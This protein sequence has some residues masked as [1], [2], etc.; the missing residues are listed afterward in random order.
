MAPSMAEYYHFWER[1]IFNAITT[2]LL[3][4]MSTYQT[5][6]SAVERKWPPLLRVKADCNGPDIDNNGLESVFRLITKLLINTIRSASSFVR[7]MDGTCVPLVAQQNAEEDQQNLFTF[8]RDVKD[9]P[10]LIEMTLNIHHNIQKIFSIIDRFLRHWKRYDKLWDPKWK[11]ELEKVAERRP[12]FVFFDFH[13]CVYKGLADSLAAYPPEKDIGFVRID[14]T[15]IVQA[16]RAQA[17][18]W[19]AAYGDILRRLAHKDLTKIQ[20]EINEYYEQLQ[21][22]PSS[23]DKLKFI[24]SVIG[25]ILSVSMDMEIRMQDV[26][27]RYRT[28]TLYKCACDEQELNDAEALPDQWQSLKDEARTKDRRM[29]KVKEQFA[30]VTQE[31]VM[32]FLE[33]TK[34]LYKQFRLDGPG[35]EEIELDDGA[36]LMRKYDV[37]VKKFQKRREELVKAQQLFGLPVQNYPEQA[38]LERDLRYLRQ[39]YE[40]Y[41]EHSAMV[42]EFSNALWSKFDINSL[43]KSADEFERRVR[44]MPKETPE[45]AELQ[46]FHKVEEVITS[47][48][49]AVP[50]IQQ[51]KSDA[52]RP[53]HWTELMTIAGQ[54]SADFD[55]KKMTLNAVFT[56]QLH[57]FPDDVNNIVVTAQQELKIKSELDKVETV[58]RNMSFLPNGLKPYKAD[59]GYT[60]MPMEEMRQT[61]EDHILSLQSMASSKYALKLLD[62]IKKWERNLST[63]GEVFDAWLQLQR[64][65]MYLEAIFLDSHD[66]RLQLPEEAKKFDRAHKQFV[67]L[68]CDTNAA[69]QVLPACCKDGRL[70]EFKAL[71]QEFDR[72]QKS[73]TDYLDTKRSAFPRFYLISDEELLSILGTSDPRAVQPHMLK[74]FDN[75]KELE[76]SRGRNVVGMYSD[77][78]EHFRFHQATPAE[79]AVEDWMRAVDEAMQDTLQRI[80]KTAVYYYASEE[81]VLWLQ[82]YVGM[83]AILATQIWWTWGV[84]DAFRKVSE[85]S[86]N[87]MKDELKKENGQVQDLVDLVRTPLHKL[88]QKKVN[89]LI[90]LDVHARDIVDSFVRDSILNK[91][92]FAW[93]SQLR[94]Y[95]D[96]KSDDVIIRQCTGKLSYCYEYQGLNGR[97]V[98]TPLTDRCV[99]TL[100]TALTFNMGGA[101]A[102]PAGTGKT[103]TT[104]DLAKALAISCI[105]TNC[106][107]GLDYRAMGVIFSGLSETGFWGCFDEFNRINVEVLSVVAAQIKTIQNGL[108]AGKK[109]VEMLGRD[110]ALKKTIGYFIT[111]NP[112]YAGR[113]ELPDNLKA[114]FRPVQMIVP[115]LLMICENMLMSEGFNMA[116]VLAKKMTVL[117]SLAQGQLSK[118]YHYDFKL[119]ALKSVLV[120]AG[121]LKRGSPDLTEDL[122]LMRALRDMNMPKFVK[123]DVPLFQD[124]LNDLFPGLNCPRVGNEALKKGI[125]DFFE[126]SKMKPK[127]EEIY[128]LQVD[129]VMQ[130][131][132]TMLTRHSTMVVGPT[133]GG[134]SVVLRAL[135]AGQHKALNLPTRLF[136]LNPKSITTDELYGILNPDTRDWTDGLL[137]KIFR[138]INGPLTD[139]RQERRYI[140]YDGDVDAI[141]IENMNSVMDDNKLLTLTNGERIRLERHCAMLFEVFDLQYAS[142]ATVSRCG[143]LFVDDKNL[144]PSPFYDHWVRTKAT[145]KLKESLE[146]LWDKYMPSLISYIFDGRHGDT[147]GRPLSKFI[148][149]SNMGT[150]SVVQFASLFDSLFDEG[151]TLVEHCENIYIFSL[152]W[153]L[154]AVLDEKGRPEFDEFLKKTANRGLPKPPIFDCYFDME[155]SAWLPWDKLMEEFKP[156]PGIDF[157]KIFVPTM[158]TTRY[159]WVTKKFISMNFPVLFVGESGTAKSV[160][161][162]NTLES[163]PVETSAILNINFSSRTSSRDFQRTLTD[164][165]SKRTGRIFGPEQGKKLRVFIDDLSM[166]KIDTYGTQQ[167]L[168]LLKFLMERAFLYE[169]GGDLLQIII[170]DCQYVS[171]MQ[172]PTAGRNPIDPR[173]VSLYAIIGVTT[174]SPETVER[175][176]TSILKNSFYAFEAPI[177]EVAQKLPQATMTLHNSIIDKMPPTP[178]KFHYIFSLRDLSRVHQGICQITPQV[179]QGNPN[180]LVRLW[181]NECSRIYEDRLNDLKDKGFVDEGQMQSIIKKDFPKAAETALV[182]P[183]VWGDFR[184]IVNILVKSETP[185]ADPRVYE[186]LGSWSDVRPILDAVLSNYNADRTPMQLVLFDDALGHL[187]R[188]HRILR[189]TRGM[190]MLIGI[191][192]SGKQSLVRLGTFTA[193]Y[194]LFEVTLSRGYGDEQLREDLKVLYTATIKQ[195]MTFLFTDA[196]VVEEGFLEYI[197]NILT[198][199]MVPALFAD[200]EKEPLLGV[201]RARAR[202]EGTPETSMWAYACGVIRDNLHLVLAMSPAGSVL[203]TRC[204]NFPGMVA[205]C[206]I[207]WF[208]SWPQEALLAVSHYFLAQVKLPDDNRSGINEII[209]AVHLSVTTKYS[210][211][212]EVKF[213][214]RNFATPKNFLDFL[215]NY[216]KFLEGN[217][218]NLETMS[219]R[220]GG[221]LDKLVQAGEKVAELSAEL[222]IKKVK[223]DANTEKVRDLMDTIIDATVKVTK[224]QEEAAAAA[225][226]ISKDAV[227]ID[228]EAAS[229]DE[230]LKAAMPALAMAEEALEQLEKKDITE[231]KSMATPPPPVM[232]VC[233]CVAILKPLGKEDDS[234]SW[235]AAKAMLADVNLRKCLQEYKKDEMQAKQVNKIRGLMAK[236]KETFE[237]DKMKSISKA[238]FGLLQW[239][240]AMVTYYD[241]AKG[242]E[243][244]RIRVAELQLQ[245]EQAEENLASITKELEELGNQLQKLTADEKEQ[246]ETL[247][248]L[249]DEA[250]SMTRKLNAASQLISGLASER[251]RWTADL[252][253]MSEVRKRLVGDCL[254]CAGFVSYAGPFNHQ[255]RTEMTYNDWQMKVKERS[256]EKSDDF[257][258]QTLLTSD[259]EIAAW[260]GHGLPSDELCVQ[261][262]ILVTRSSRWPLC[263]DPQMQI[264]S[265]IK[266]KEEKNLMVKTFNED[267]IKFLELAV[268]YGKPFLFENL[269]EEIDPMIDP[270]LEKRYVFK[271]GQKMIELGENE[272]EWNEAF[273][274]MMTTKLS[275]PKYTPEV[276]G[277]ASI[278]NCVITLEGLAAQLLNVVVSFERPDLE[279]LRQK[280]VMQMSE[281]RQIIKSLEDTL[282][283][284]LAAAKGSILENDELIA[285][286]N[287]AKTKSIEINASLET[288]AK[289]SEEIDKT[290]S[291]YQKVAKRG[292]ILYFAMAGLVAISEMYEYSLSGYLGVFETALKEAKPDKIVENRLKNLRD[293]MTQ[294]MYDYTCMGLFER[295]KLLFSFQMTTMILDGDGELIHPEFEFYM[296][297]NPSLEKVK[298]PIPHAF[299][300]EPGWKDLQLLKTLHD[301]L[302]TLCDDI[303]NKG[304]LWHTWYDGEAPESV[305]LPCNFSEKVDLFKQVL[306][307]RCLRPDRMITATKGFIAKKLT[308]YFVQPPSL[309]YDKIFEKSNEKMPIVFILSP[310]ADPQSDV[311]KL[312]DVLGFSGSKFKFVS[313]GQGMGDNAALSIEQGFLKGH[314][315]MLQNCHLLASW[316]KTLEK[317]LELMNKPHK[318]FR[319]WLTTMPTTAFPMGILQRSLKVVTEPPEGLKLNIKQSYAKISDAD[320]DG[321]SSGAFRSLIYV[322]AFFHAIVQDRRKFGRIGWNVAYDFNESDYKI[323]ARLLNLYLQKCF[324]KNEVT[325]WET[326]RYL[327]GEAMYGGRVTDQYDRRVLNT[328]L[329]EYLGD[330]IFDQNVKFFFSRAGHDYGLPPEGNAAHYQAH[331]L[332]L[333]INQSPSVFGLHPNAEINYF[334]S[335]AQ[336]IY[337]GLLAMQTG[338]SGDGGGM[339]RDDFIDKT[340][341]EIIK[342]IPMDE[343]KLYKDGVPN[344]LEVVLMQETERFEILSKKM[345]GNLSDLR[346]AIK[347]DIGMSQQLDD[348]GTSMYNGQLPLVWSKAAP[349]TQKPLGSWMEHFLRRYKQY[350]DW[351]D[352]GQPSVF[353]LSGLHI[354]ESLN[355]ALVQASCRRRGWA[356][357]KSTLY[358]KVTKFKDES[359]LTTPLLDGSY[360][361]GFY[362]EGARWDFDNGCLARQLPKVLIQVMPIIEVIPAEANRLKL[363]DELPTPVYITQLRRNAMGVGLVF[364]ANLHTKEHPSLWILQGVAMML[365]DNS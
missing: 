143:M 354:P 180:L 28:L 124:L 41:L 239:V 153:S 157:N 341:V 19:V 135:A 173:V 183:L 338:D 50:L 317:I 188:V 272:I 320:L 213:K 39:V 223:V 49:L 220:L 269:D 230:A 104:K 222:E 168:A 310:G 318:D 154:G 116:K 203:K 95:W 151:N 256:I 169:R 24:L 114:L 165:V 12:P 69:P 250:D 345:M 54:D 22:P 38:Q 119:R 197:N 15:A 207:D 176:Y 91:E 280:L 20:A 202:G 9:N 33:E 46:T 206:T 98:I 145:D 16:I 171:G 147:I 100:T 291:L 281:N 70:E 34:E 294:T 236:D 240:K 137:S 141:W 229:A 40:I 228:S 167:P 117:Y 18:D 303:K 298:D 208:F 108:D 257:K 139:G 52:I 86:K 2:M 217:R 305:P 201:I 72:I 73:L 51:L 194:K 340:A 261:N 5:L 328:Y 290:R 162:Q 247:K 219:T 322:L 97:L 83:A 3:R 133:G 55:I 112:G 184:D 79:G 313:L 351:C 244:K 36:E 292:S 299:I 273:V 126:E 267:Y 56:M 212:F 178:T 332:T 121:D 149:R 93:E 274:L 221:G 232:V 77:E 45:L 355:S 74:L 323:S 233:A 285:T 76:F 225:D 120:M 75:C 216:T 134:K 129:K 170:K 87:A 71:T 26:R 306:I 152:V 142:P 94:F 156:A 231:I 339:S 37:D 59:R 312:G 30:H 92:E 62:T 199:G 187:I 255:F 297:G 296:K 242:V 327:I 346:R 205:G 264:V 333:P 132:E 11:Q 300:S 21:E 67:K 111:M 337:E 175:I 304:D 90:I 191:G 329:L 295:H 215:F 148:Q 360:M 282:L 348:I 336:D 182:S 14:S 1:R 301:G 289:T 258:L 113:S 248:G 47:F 82:K 189:L 251:T 325:P 63:V 174:P 315:V 358:T 7:W 155:M 64:K 103:E 65:W 144:G 101:P 99:M 226:Q 89:T 118:Q 164:N 314:W 241:V 259:V 316:L 8:H 80:S 253:N 263:V 29:E 307:I 146:D 131:Y 17:M 27:E 365:N 78:G 311:M 193:G 331:V 123:Q 265:W 347:G 158:D 359:E 195:P 293:K 61:L 343:L 279:E 138:E 68:M 190:A 6:F 362:L 349:Q 181:R 235:S 326:L 85:G 321:C 218:K 204:R 44:K 227:I 283:R 35:S 127:N 122:V 96:R 266:S 109:F 209:A 278:V 125:E 105:V 234:G 160:T 246:S 243:P 57:R 179:V 245:K 58:W 163:F 334:M 350:R 262:G 4:G 48:K 140:L 357:D 166:P 268:M 10:A 344:P 238:G 330:F 102:G 177:Q 224:R 214:R 196:H 363:R 150:D 198:V 136:P 270:V 81:R 53:V 88:Q 309:V 185:Y 237:G 211:Q 210:P 128:H 324:D 200:D 288:A 342:S 319:L 254:V 249:K 106:G 308:E 32:A 43:L 84:E 277:K 275:N 284:E 361:S 260:S 287:N 13:I 353:W 23:L 159:A 364:E 107:D 192:G 115:D 276:M 252:E 31:Q 110:V 66:I 186:D 130:L 172:P 302:K 356:L 60:L 25:Q 271:N 42:S 286:L 352:K 161:M 335:S